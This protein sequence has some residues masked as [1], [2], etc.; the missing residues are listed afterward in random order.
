M[1][2]ERFWPP[3]RLDSQSGHYRIFGGNRGP[4]RV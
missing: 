3:V 1:L 2:N 4:R